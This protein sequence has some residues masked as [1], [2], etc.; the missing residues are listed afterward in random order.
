M[1]GYCDTPVI[2]N[3]STQ[4]IL[5]IGTES[6]Q[7]KRAYSNQTDRYKKHLQMPLHLLLS[8]NS[9]LNDSLL[10]SLIF[11]SHISVCLQI[12]CVH[13]FHLL[14]QPLLRGLSLRSDYPLKLLVY[15]EHLLR[16]NVLYN[17]HYIERTFECQ[18]YNAK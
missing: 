15:N 5:C 1:I 12:L 7:G 6:T 17:C 13:Y 2:L 3:G 16:T 14:S 8:S 18:Y 11:R 9:V 10:T 4:T